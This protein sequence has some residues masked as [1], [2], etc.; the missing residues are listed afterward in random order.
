MLTSEP[1]RM[2]SER[3]QARSLVCRHAGGAGGLGV[4]GAVGQVAPQWGRSKEQKGDPLGSAPLPAFL[5]LLP[6]VGSGSL[7][8]SSW[9]WLPFGDPPGVE[10]P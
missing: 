8:V 4:P 7:S 3:S 10:A 6:Q 5:E 2:C 1:T 9:H